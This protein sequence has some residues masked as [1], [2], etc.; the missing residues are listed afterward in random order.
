[1][2][3]VI[4]LV[5]AALSGCA[6]LDNG[7]MAIS[8]GISSHDPVTGQRQIS[9]T[10]ETEEIQK[11]EEFTRQF[12]EEARQ[13]GLKVDAETP[14]YPQVVRVFE[15]LKTVVHRQNLPWAVHV[16]ENPEWNAFTVGGGKAFV[17]TGI[18]QGSLGL[19]D[20]NELAAV[21]AH[22]MAHVAARHSSEKGGKLLL[23]RMVD[24]GTKKRGEAFAASFTTNQEDEADR[25]SALYLA[26]AGYDPAAAVNVWQRMHKASGSYV[27]EMLH[28]HPLNDDRT[29][30]MEAYATAVKQYYVPGK[31][32]PD[33]EQLLLN[34]TLYSYKAPAEVKAGEGGGLLALL[35]TATNAY[36]EA[37]NAK[38]EQ[39]SRQQKQQEQIA[40]AGQRIRF[41]GVKIANANTG[42]KGLFGVVTNIS[43]KA[44]TQAM[45]SIEYLNG[46]QVVAR[47]D[48]QLP[49]LQ[50]N[51]Q[52]NFGFVLQAIPYSGVSIR[53]VYVQLADE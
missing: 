48:A 22:E 29:K 41:S 5:A 49:S 47:Q 4:C 26:L 33:H 12:L 18:F 43:G 10:S 53:P 44:V 34:N 35:E 36:T 8:N 16:I 52:K 1:M 3:M 15:R 19:K 50:V 2:R 38:Q 32:N 11:S 13:G 46:Q 14:Y 37:A 39:A 9:L 51:E 24:K 21:L 23:T 40:A 7:L 30:N 25:Y 45:A 6:A 42:G 31:L 28:D 20:D 27:G 17:L